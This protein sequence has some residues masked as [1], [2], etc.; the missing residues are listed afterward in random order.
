MKKSLKRLLARLRTATGGEFRKP[1]SARR[2]LQEPQ[3]MQAV[4]VRARPR[5]PS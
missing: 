4:P 2:G 3:R 5:R 1:S